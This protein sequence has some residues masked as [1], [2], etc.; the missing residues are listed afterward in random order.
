MKVL[1]LSMMISVSAMAGGNISTYVAD[2]LENT[3]RDYSTEDRQKT[4]SF[5]KT[6]NR[7][8]ALRDNMVP[9]GSAV[10]TN[11]GN[12]QDSGIK[13]V[14]HAAYGDM[15]GS[16]GI[17]KPSLESIKKA[18][19]NSILVAKKSG[20]KS[21][22]FPLLGGGIFLG[23]TGATKGELIHTIMD[24]ALLYNKGMEIAFVA[25]APAEQELFA[26]AFPKALESYSTKRRL[27]K[28]FLLGRKSMKKRAAV[29]NGSVTDYNLH[30][31]EVIVN[32]ANTEIMIGGG[33]SGVIGRATGEASLMDAD[34]QD[35]KDALIRELE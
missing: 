15:S 4:I 17:Y 34:G 7:V 13:A 25:Y 35:V 23:R 20:Y 2:R 12:L 22:A 24:A 11:A 26:K 16:D 9:V 10:L 31:A 21:I 18:V 33:L 3:Y 5:F 1:L 29:Y 14:V 28:D 27:T 30:G 6:T 32:A 19:I 8:E